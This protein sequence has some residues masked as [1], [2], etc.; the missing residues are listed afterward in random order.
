MIR[1]FQESDRERM[2]EITAEVFGQF[3]RLIFLW[4][5]LES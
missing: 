1:P 3:R 5:D 2:K 4:K